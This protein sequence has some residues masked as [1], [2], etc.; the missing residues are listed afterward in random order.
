MTD[1][2][3][4]NRRFCSQ[5]Y[6]HRKRRRAIEK[7]SLSQ[8]SLAQASQS[9]CHAPVSR[10]CALDFFTPPAMDLAFHHCPNLRRARGSRLPS[11]AATAR[12]Q[13]GFRS[14]HPLVGMYTLARPATRVLD[15][16][17]VCVYQLAIDHLQ[18]LLVLIPP[19]AGKHLVTLAG[20]THAFQR[21]HPG[22]PWGSHLHLPQTC[23]TMRH[24]PCVSDRAPNKNKAVNVDSLAWQAFLF[25]CRNLHLLPDICP[26]T[27][28][29][30]PA[31]C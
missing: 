27:P 13:C 21:N 22:P 8:L 24:P 2:R 14:K 11:T 9:V 29:N 19:L 6:G 4:K 12:R 16:V 31:R 18:P 25:C 28:R 17:C 1:E 5:T 15:C 30:N 10:H 20:S 3:L 26:A 23:R 7:A